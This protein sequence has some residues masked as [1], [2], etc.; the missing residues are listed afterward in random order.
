MRR[1]SGLCGF[2]EVV[3]GAK[4][5]GGW[6]WVWESI[7]EEGVEFEDIDVDVDADVDSVDDGISVAEEDEGVVM[8]VSAHTRKIRN[9]DLNM[10]KK[11]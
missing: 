2:G 7:L 5:F 11:E 3:V 6:W 4:D 9:Q 8:E 1:V 10:K